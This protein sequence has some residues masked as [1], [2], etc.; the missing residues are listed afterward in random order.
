MERKINSFNPFFSEF[1]RKVKMRQTK[2]IGFSKHCKYFR[3]TFKNTMSG[4][5]VLYFNAGLKVDLDILRK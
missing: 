5:R 4:H 2:N 3:L 1:P